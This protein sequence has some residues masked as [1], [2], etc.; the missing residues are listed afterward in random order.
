MADTTNLEKGIT[1]RRDGKLWVVMEVHFVSPGK[2]SAFY[3]TKLK[4]LET[5]KVVEVTLKSGLEIEIVETY[6]RNCSYLYKEGEKYLFM[7]DE[8]YEQYELEEKLLDANMPKYLLPEQKVT[9]LFDESDRVIMANFLKTKLIF[10][11]VEAPPGLKGD[12]SGNATRAAKIDSG[13]EVQVPLF[14]KE[15]EKIVVNVDTDE[16]CERAK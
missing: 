2:G 9:V 11:V 8:S 4:E 15:G 14:I 10:T 6:R 7:D 5:G 13:A 1:I 16:Y 3:K 12:T